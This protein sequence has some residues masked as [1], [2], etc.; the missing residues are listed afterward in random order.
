MPRNPAGFW[1]GLW[2]GLTI[3]FSFI[4]SL[5]NDTIAIYDVNNNGGWYDWGFNTGVGILIMSYS[6]YSGP[7]IQ[8]NFKNF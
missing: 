7:K 4:G 5:F 1:W 2:N 3:G 6:A 8:I